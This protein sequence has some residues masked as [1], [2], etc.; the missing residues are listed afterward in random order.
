M[1]VIRKIGNSFTPSIKDALAGNT[2]E[3]QNQEVEQ[4]TIF[5]QFQ[6]LRNEP[7]TKEQFEAKWN[8]Y[9]DLIADRPNLRS[10]L[11][12]MPELTDGNKLLLRIG[13]SVQEEEVRIAKPE[14]MT[15]LRNELQND[16]IELTTRFEKVETERV[17]FSD[18]EKMQMMIQKNPI[19]FEL[20]Q[21]FN[22]D[23]KD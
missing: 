23:F 16:A 15:W 8:E 7:F 10:T 6:E 17:I 18:S 2:P 22:L 13:N 3:K 14:L 9:L 5:S 4:K 19:L 12:A 11:S 1:K 21:K 20:K